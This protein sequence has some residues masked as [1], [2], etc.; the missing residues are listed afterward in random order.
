MGARPST[1]RKSGGFLNGI[2]GL[3]TGY[4]MTDEFNG[5]A[6]TPGK[7][8]GKDKF[9][10]LYC[11][12]SV[13]VDGAEEDV[14]T[15][16]FMG[17]AEDWEVSDDGLTIT[18]AEEGRQLGA[19]T[20]F[21]TFLTSLC[22]NGFDESELP[23]DEFNFEPIIGLRCHF[24]QKKNEEAT[25]KLGKRKS[26]D[27]TKEY[28]RQ[29]LVVETVYGREDVPANKP[30][31]GK[32]AP[33]VKAGK[34][35]KPT[36]AVPANA[37]ATLLAVLSE[38]PENKITFGKLAVKVL[39]HTVKAKAVDGNEQKEWLKNKDNIASVDGI[40]MDGDVIALSE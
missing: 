38:Q 35:A 11:V 20:S 17:G 8:G 23:E 15:T 4:Q 16:L 25:K 37:A 27:G 34:Q 40:E 33:A 13:R 3:I 22:E 30:A 39:Q 29:D 9:H 36:S 28:D 5:V 24:V 26:K 18:P 12:L 7:K 32:A 19:G 2:D 14:T 31:K 21:S 1:F 10:A 6:F